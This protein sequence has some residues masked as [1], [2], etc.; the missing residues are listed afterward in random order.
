MRMLVVTAPAAEAELAADELWRRGVAAVE[1]RPVAGDGVD[2]RVELRTTV[3]DDEPEPDGLRWPWRF[4]DV[5]PEPATTWRDHAQPVTV[6]DSVMTIPAWIEAAVPDGVTGVRIEPGA[7]FGLGDHPTTQLSLRLLVPE[8]DVRPGGRVLDV[9]C[10]SGVLGIVAA[11]RGA[12]TVRALDVSTAA[13]EATRDNA[14]R[15]GVGGVVVA[16][17][18]P[19]GAVDGVWDIVVANI[20]APTLVG[21]APDLR[22]VTAPGGVVIVSGVLARRHDHV[23]EA[24]SP[25]VVRAAAELDGWAAVALSPPD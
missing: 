21:L 13:V 11:R 6:A 25:F 20:L 4:E 22:R 14:A 15:N 3:G 9:G 24:M 8:I 19:L 23:L 5:D 18:A 2:A 1:E 12:G 16:D 10:G 7:A 17:A